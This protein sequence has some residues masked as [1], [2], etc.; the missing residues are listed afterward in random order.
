MSLYSNLTILDLK[1]FS[2]FLI[3]S[4]GLLSGEVD[5]GEENGT[6]S[7]WERGSADGTFAGLI[8]TGIKTIRAVDNRLSKKKASLNETLSL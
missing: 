3:P 2:C 1:I 5:G 6:F 4:G 8:L 7:S